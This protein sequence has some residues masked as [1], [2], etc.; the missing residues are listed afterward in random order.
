M[1]KYIKKAVYPLIN[2]WYHFREY[3]RVNRNFTL[4]G[5]SRLKKEVVRSYGLVEAPPEII[6]IYWEALEL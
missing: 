1:I 4:T 2:S 5:A 3:I 6:E